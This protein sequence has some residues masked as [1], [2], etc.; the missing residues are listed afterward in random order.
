M[1]CLETLALLSVLLLSAA[2]AHQE[3]RFFLPVLPFLHVAVAYA[4]MDILD[5][6]APPSLRTAVYRV[7]QAVGGGDGEV[8]REDTPTAAEPAEAGA[9][10]AVAGAAAGPYAGHEG[11]HL[12]GDMSPLLISP[13]A[14]SYSMYGSD[15]VDGG[16]G[17]DSAGE[18]E[19]WGSAGRPE[20]ESLLSRQDSDGAASG[21]Q[22][23]A[24]L[25]SSSYAG[26][27]GRSRGVS[28]GSGSGSSGGH[29]HG[30]ITPHG[31]L[32][33]PRWVDDGASVG[34]TYFLRSFD[35]YASTEVPLPPLPMPFPLPLFPVCLPPPPSPTQTRT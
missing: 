5:R 11:D 10:D 25:P 13:P 16:E 15:S 9:G 7:L 18:R 4:T 28:S 27:G 30:R 8:G 6:W 19:A 33:P 32:P 21:S 3:V 14:H 34:S 12:P 17:S 2:T 22:P 29:G 26:A 24:A 31:R 1:L 35:S 23:S 20:R